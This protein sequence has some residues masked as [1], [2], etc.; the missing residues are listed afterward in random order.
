MVTLVDTLLLLDSAVYH[1]CIRCC[2]LLPRFLH[3]HCI[4]SDIVMY[5]VLQGD[6]GQE[7]QPRWCCSL[8]SAHSLEGCSCC[9]PCCSEPA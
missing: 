7:A 9:S 8:C 1:P 5:I 6:S 3:A 2:A 4:G